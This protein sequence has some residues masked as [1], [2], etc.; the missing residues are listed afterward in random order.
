MQVPTVQYPRVIWLG[1]SFRE[2]FAGSAGPKDPRIRSAELK[3][4]GSSSFHSP[5]VEVRGILSY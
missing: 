2:S 4:R 1:G 5:F 3:S